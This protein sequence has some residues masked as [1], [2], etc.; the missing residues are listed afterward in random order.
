MDL[1]N[2]IIN[3][4]NDIFYV[5][6]TQPYHGFLDHDI[7][8][9]VCE[10]DSHNNIES[11]SFINDIT[12]VKNDITII[13]QHPSSIYRYYFINLLFSSDYHIRDSVFKWWD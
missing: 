12:C 3:R 11:S 10:L 2:K 13:E 8:L 6:D 9:L 5:Y 1:K 4:H 7:L